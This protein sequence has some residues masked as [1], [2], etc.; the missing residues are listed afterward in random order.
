[1]L[2][3][4]RER[5]RLFMKDKFLA[6]DTRK[7][8]LQRDVNTT[9]CILRIFFFFFGEGEGIDSVSRAHRNRP[10]PMMPDFSICQ[11]APEDCMGSNLRS[12]PDNS[13]SYKTV[14]LYC[15]S[16][17]KASLALRHTSEFIKC[18]CG[19]GTENHRG[20]RPRLMSAASAWH[21]A[22]LRASFP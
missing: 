12:E 1:M 19:P 21:C 20:L 11:S 8:C 22:Q 16:W 14:H 4:R 15:T 2:C 17:A 18:F 13:K 7:K 5:D 10:V 6:L 3:D 9:D